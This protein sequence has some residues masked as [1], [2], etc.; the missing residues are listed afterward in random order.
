MSPNPPR[1]SVRIKFK[2][3]VDTGE[4][5]ELL[6]DDRAPDRSEGYH[7]KVAGA[8]AKYLVRNPEVEDAGPRHATDADRLSGK[9]TDGDVKKDV[10]AD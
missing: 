1:P 7:D 6:V 4:I 3:N 5:E 9:R 10:Q 8:I 2:F